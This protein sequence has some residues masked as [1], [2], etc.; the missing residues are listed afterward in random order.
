MRLY[1]DGCY[2]KLEFAQENK[3]NKFYQGGS[4]LVKIK[5]E[6]AKATFVSWSL[7]LLQSASNL[8]EMETSS[9]LKGFNFAEVA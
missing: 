5:N 6:D 4:I 7:Y 8:T 3:L 9:I 2:L 1:L